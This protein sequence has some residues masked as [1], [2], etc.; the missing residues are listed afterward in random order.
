MKLAA[1]RC[2]RLGAFPCAAE[3]T[4]EDLLCDM[5]RAARQDTGHGAVPGGSHFNFRVP[6]GFQDDAVQGG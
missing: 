3:A 2:A 4:Q 5:C 6:A 1:C